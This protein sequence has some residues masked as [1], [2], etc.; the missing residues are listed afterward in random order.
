MKRLNWIQ[1]ASFVAISSALAA[2]GTQADGPQ[3]M[4]GA[5]K[6]SIASTHQYSANSAPYKWGQRLD[7]VNA[8]PISNATAGTEGGYSWRD[9]DEIQSSTDHQRTTVSIETETTRAAS[10]GYRWGVRSDAD[11]TGYRWG[12][13]SDAEQSDR[14]GVRS[15]AEQ[16]GYRWGV[17]SDA[18]SPA[19]AGASAAMLNSPA[20]A[21]ASAAML[22][23]PA[24]AGASAAMLTRPATAGASAAMLT[25][26]ATAGASAAMLTRPATAGASAAM[27]TRPATAGASANVLPNNFSRASRS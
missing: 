17:R 20:T 19:T 21:G 18:D 4:A 6:A 23:R 3:G 16:S 14:W 10:T 26:P 11:Q 15:D 13:R 24:T 9:S 25:R 2:S 22:T 8:K 27:L 1:N 7:A 12:V 5:V